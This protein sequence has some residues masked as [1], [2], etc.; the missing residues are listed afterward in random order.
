MANIGEQLS[1]EKKR[2]R[3]YVDNS[4]LPVVQSSAPKFEQLRVKQVRMPDE[5]I[6]G[7]YAM[8]RQ[9]MD[10]RPVKEETITASTVARLCIAYTLERIKEKKAGNALRGSTEDELLSVFRRVLV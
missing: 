9:L 7:L 5:M 1:Q 6:E 3:K 2:S 8:A 10:Q 4:I